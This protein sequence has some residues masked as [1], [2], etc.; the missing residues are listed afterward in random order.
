M[1][2]RHAVLGAFVAGMLAAGHPA[3]LLLV[4]L[5][6]PRRPWLALALLATAFAGALAAHARV[7]QLDRSALR[8]L[9]GRSVTERVVLL[10][11]PR[12][13]SFG[14][15]QATVQL[16]G[17]RVALTAGRWIPRLTAPI[18]AQLAVSGTLKP[19]SPAQA[20]MRT[21]NVHAAL[22]ASSVRATDGRRGGFAGFVDGVRARADRALASGPVS[23]L[24][25][26]MVLGEGQA[27]PTAM[28]D[29][30]R[31]ASLTHLVAASGQNVALLAAL[32][33]ALGTALGL[34]LRGRLLLALA[35]VVLYVPL[36]GAGPSIQRA[37]IM[38]GAALVAALSGRPASRAYA[39]L[40][41]AA[42]TLL[43]NP[44]AAAD[45]G[46]QLSF[47]AVISIALGAGRVAVVLRRRR[48]P[49]G[50]AE[51]TAMTVAA[52]I[53][54][55]PL[56]ALHFGRASIVGLPANILAAPAVAPVMWL[57]AIAAA[58]GQVSTAA[59]AP[60]AALASLPAA[61]LASLGHAAAHLPGA[62]ARLPLGVVV[63]A[64]AGAAALLAARP[65]VPRVR[66]APAVALVIAALLAAVASAHHGAAPPAAL[67]IS[68]LDV[69]Q[70]D[71]TLIQ[72]GGR[73][74]LVDAGP[75]GDHIASLV[76]GEGARRLDL[77]VVT[78]AQADHEGG[79]P[80]VLSQIPVTAVLDG[81][82]VQAAARAHQTR[83]LRPLAGQVIHVGP[84]RLDVL[85][86]PAGGRVPGEDPN[87]RA[88]VMQATVDG[89]RVLLTAD[90]ESDVLSPLPLEPVDLLKV[91]HHGSADPGLPALLSTLRPRAAVIEVGRHNP[92]G[93]PAPSTL[94]ALG[95][96]GVR[97]LRTDRDGTI[98][99]ELRDGRLVE[100][101]R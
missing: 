78:H 10:D 4:A 46:W 48:V 68:F 100:S 8:P 6:A 23:G 92:Y 24:L 15:W 22:S 55:A 37:G 57:G 14:G 98:R 44:R 5:A 90:A 97:V 41:A 69:G 70:G 88:I 91:S 59:A 30:F 31:T 35:L 39:L 89:A 52:T 72:A 75:P 28:Q 67:R 96:A 61:Y 101:N 33:I 13:T 42:L 77:L 16:R 17:E 83:R 9:K 71:A 3:A 40:L 45:P 38:G 65:R 80:E 81:G 93:H 62:N 95:A 64:S 19:L 32:A 86:P 87:L 29:D 2:A 84:I 74:V 36:A 34:G 27:L 60:F 21:R 85:W 50:L 63:A 94:H 53:A 25:R 51:A 56:I 47:A 18:G 82:S 20:W 7:E 26:G 76:R 54:T 43:A 11:L 1:T 49:W 66:G 73:A 79:A 12:E 58:V 99:F